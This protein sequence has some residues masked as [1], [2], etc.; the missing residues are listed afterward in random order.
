M[1]GD[2]GWREWWEA[3]RADPELSPLFGQRSERAIPHGRD[4]GLSVAEHA[5]ALRE[6]GFAEAGPLWRSGDDTVL[7][8]LRCPVLSHPPMF[9]RPSR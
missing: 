9:V 2:E 3:V 8:A 4:N 1:T 7:L 5:D 6:A